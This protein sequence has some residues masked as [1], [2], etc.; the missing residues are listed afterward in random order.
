M[1][2]VACIGRRILVQYDQMLGFVSNNATEVLAVKS[3]QD[4]GLVDAVVVIDQK[5]NVYSAEIN[6]IT[7]RGRQ[8]LSRDAVSGKGGA[9]FA[10][11]DRAKLA[12]RQQFDADRSYDSTL[13]HITSGGIAL[14]FGLL[15]ALLKNA[16]LTIEHFII[17]MG[18]VLIW[19]V[20][21][22]GM[23]YSFRVSRRVFENDPS[24]TSDV[25]KLKKYEIDNALVGRLN[26][27][28]GIVFFCGLLAFASF[29]VLVVSFGI[30]Q[31][32]S[33]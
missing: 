10:L 16:E 15:P 23:L 20:G 12:I 5:R 18:A 6:Q 8:V 4:A 3:L 9:D 21:L 2:S 30:K 7:A 27:L 32:S 31:G 25:I 22:L 17:W 24:L 33:T 19:I 29:V 26:I 13:L 28:N 11:S 14:A 1:A